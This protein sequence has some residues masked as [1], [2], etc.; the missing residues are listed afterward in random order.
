MKTLARSYCD[1]SVLKFMTW[2]GVVIVGEHDGLVAGYVGPVGAELL[3]FGDG[4]MAPLE[5]GGD[6]ISPAKLRDQSVLV[7]LIRR[8]RLVGIAKDDLL[9]YLHR[10]AVQQPRIQSTQ[11]ILDVFRPPCS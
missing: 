1:P 5:L 4:P 3:E 11:D 9:E 7:I 6:G 10:L 8:D 2:S